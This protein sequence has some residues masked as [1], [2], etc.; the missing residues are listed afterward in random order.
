MNVYQE[1]IRALQGLMKRDGIDAIMILDLQNYYYFTGDLRKQPRVFIPREGDPSILVFNG[2]EDIVRRDCWIKDVR[3]YNAVHQ[4]MVAIIDLVREHGYSEGTVGMNFDFSLPAFLHER[5]K[6]ANPSVKV[7]DAKDTIMEL[8][9]VKSQQEV[10]LIRKAEEIAVAGL[11]WARILMRRGMTEIE[12]AGE[13]EYAM[14][15]AGAEGFS[16]PTFV[17][18]GERVS[19][20]HGMAT[21]NRLKTGDPVLIDVGPVF[22]GYS[23]NMTRIFSLGRP[24]ESLVELVK[25]YLE[26]REAAID[27]AKPGVRVMMLDNAFYEALKKYGWGEYQIRGIAHGVGLNF[28]EKPFSTIFPED[29]LVELEENMVLSFGHPILWVPGKG[30]ARVEDIFL[31]TKGGPE[32]LV[33]YPTDIISVG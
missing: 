7:V 2:E 27:A 3:T 12:L 5:F 17:N 29:M 31:L 33:D 30:A 20:L 26:A 4:M 1:R 23:G 19:S 32:R 13:I 18:A 28:E 9:M 15:R 6:L 11:E 21:A 22:S 24:S 16:F 14:R 10:E 25:V 8:R